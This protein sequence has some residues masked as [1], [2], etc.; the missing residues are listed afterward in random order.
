M[1]KMPPMP[2]RIAGLPKDSRGYPVPW[3][4]HWADGV[5]DFRVIGDGKLEHAVKFRACWV[6]GQEM[7][8]NSAFVIGAGAD[9]SIGKVHRFTKTAG[10]GPRFTGSG[11]VRMIGFTER[12]YANFDDAPTINLTNSWE[13]ITT[14][15]RATLNDGFIQMRVV[16]RQFIST[17]AVGQ[18]LEVRMSDHPEVTQTGISIAATGWADVDT[19]WIDIVGNPENNAGSIEIRSSGTGAVTNNCDLT[20]MF[21]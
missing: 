6:C 12:A 14:T 10:S 7:G 1:T 19:G 4:V 13:T 11:N 20:V 2:A 16:G 3:F 9:L 8:R 21:R 18:T 15:F 5:P 17:A